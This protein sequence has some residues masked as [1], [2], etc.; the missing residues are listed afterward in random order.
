MRRAMVSTCVPQR[1]SAGQEHLKTPFRDHLAVAIVHLNLA[2]AGSNEAQTPIEEQPQDQSSEI[3]HPALH[4]DH[5][6]AG[7]EQ[8]LE[9]VGL[10]LY[11]GRRVDLSSCPELFHDHPCPSPCLTFA[12]SLPTCRSAVVPVGQKK[13]HILEH[14]TVAGQIPV[15]LVIQK[16]PRHYLRPGGIRT[17]MEL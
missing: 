15:H 13:S 10:D 1:A 3:D 6:T 16:E 7:K 4:T 9:L 8:R 2:F 5:P 11:Y 17:V 12:N 14:C